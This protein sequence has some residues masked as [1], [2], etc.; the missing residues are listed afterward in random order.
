MAELYNVYCDESCHLENDGQRAMVLG[1][2]WCRNDKRKEIAFRLKEIKR[3]HSLPHKFESKWTKVSPGKVEFYK[4]FIDYFFDDDDLYFRAIIV[5]DKTVLDHETFKQ[6]H[7]EWYYKMYFDMLKV[8]FSPNEAYRIFID[9]KD[10]L[11]QSKLKKLH[12]VLCK[13]QYDFSRNIIKDV[14]I[15]RTNENVLMELADLLIGAISYANRELETSKAKLELVDRIKKR[16][17]YTLRDTTLYREKK[18]NI[19]KWRATETF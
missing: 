8:I 2:L 17:G 6:D 4:D 10:T 19:L 9:I 1:A 3:K 7:D 13:N 11:G 14:K 16:S 12:D 18:V 5:P 15:T